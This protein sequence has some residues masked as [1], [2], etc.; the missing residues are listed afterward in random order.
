MAVNEKT[1]AVIQPYNRSNVP[2]LDV[3]LRKYIQDELQRLE[4][5][6]RSLNTAGIEV[7]DEPPLNPVRGMVKYN[8]TPW[9]ALGN[10]S[11][12]LVVYNGTAWVAV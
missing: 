11:E 5:S 1:N 8:I 6:I 12:G 7:L 4:A 9:D 10:G 3:D 2:V